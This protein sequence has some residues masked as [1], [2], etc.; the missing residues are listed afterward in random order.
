MAA[1]PDSIP[2]APETGISARFRAVRAFTEALTSTLETEDFVVQTMPDVS[3]TK[4]HLAHVTWFF[5]NFLLQPHLP[6]YRVFDD[7][8][9]FIFNSYY[10]QVGQMHARPERG[11]LTRPT[12]DEVFDYR[13]H[14]D[15]HMHSLIEQH[16]DNAD[17]MALVELGINHEQQ[18]Q[19]LLLTD[20]KHVFSKNP[21][22]PAF[23]KL[24]QARGQVKG[25]A[26]ELRF[27][28]GPSDRVTIGFDGEGF[29]YDNEGPAHDVILQ[30]Y[31]I[32]NRPVT[33]REFVEFIADGGYER[34][35]YWLSEGWATVNERGWRRPFYWLDDRHEFSLGGVREMDPDEPVSHLSYFEAD[36]FATWAGAR[37][38]TE[39][40]WEVWARRYPVKGN[41]ADDGRYHPA[42]AS[43]NNDAVQV[44][45]DVWEWT[46]SA[47]SAY[48]G[49]Q[50]AKGAVGEYNGK[51]MCSQLVLRGGSCATSA[52]HI[53]PTYR[54]FFYP[55]DQWQF[56]GLRLARAV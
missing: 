29:A 5:E 27:I 36:A 47:Y 17:V 12:V 41:F 44:Y 54:N 56:T 49:Y 40:E 28:E 4:W 31:E 9:N 14:V 33:N 21:L 26:P 20:I 1:T 8:F 50:P 30:P 45:G 15:E 43:G 18:H 32:A 22:Q 34:S 39:A 42:P 35:E 46:R 51:F 55:A 3:P 13:A 10:Y 23:H 2:S 37:L 38:P 53:R 24:P 11:L 52:S 7:R 6:G 25:K 16:G 19:E 48:P